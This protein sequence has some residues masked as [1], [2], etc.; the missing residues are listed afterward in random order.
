M[1]FIEQIFLSNTGGTIANVTAQNALKVDG[2]AVNQPVTKSGSW[3]NLGI[4]G[5]TITANAGTNLNTSAL[6]LESGG[7]LAS[8]K[9]KTDNLDVLLSTRL[10]PADTLAAI[11]TV[12]TITNPVAVTKSGTWSNLGISGGTINT[13]SNV[14]HIDDNSGSLTVDNGGTFAVQATKSGTWS[15]LGISGGTIAAT[16]SGTWNINTLTSI[17]NPI[18]VTKSGTWSNLGISGGTIASTQSGNW[19]VRNQD[20]AGNALTTNSTTPSAK[21]ALDQNIVSILG[22]APTT[23]GKL[24]IKGADGDVFVRQ[25]TAANL[26]AT[27]VGTGTFA[28]QAAKSGT[29]SNL[30]IS[31]GT[32]NTISNVIHIDDNAG[33]LT[34]DNGGT[35][36]VQASKSG[37][38]SNLGISGGTITVTQ[39]TGTNLHTVVDSGTISTITNVVHVDDNAGSLTVDNG[40]TF[41]VQATK[42]GTWSNLGIS[43]GTIAATQSGTWNVGTVSTLTTITNPVAVTKSGAWTNLGISGGTINTITNVVHIDDNS[44]SLTVD[45]GGTFAVQAAKSGAWTNLGISGGTIAVTQATASNLNATVVGTGT[46]AVQESG[47]QLIVDNAGFTDGTSKLIMAGYIF[48]EVAGT[49][50][51]ENDAAAARINANRAKVGV[52][53]DGTTR[54]RYATVTAA[55][56]LK[57]DASGVAVP[58]TDNSGS[59]TVDA[60]VGTPL[61]ATV[62]PS[63]T[64]GWTMFS[65]PNNNSNTPLTT[66]VVTVKGSAGTLGGYFIYNPNSTV[67]FVQVFDVSGTVTLG[68]TRPNVMF[69]IPPLSSANMEIGNGLNFANA[70]KIAATTTSSGSVAPTTGLEV[71]MWY[72]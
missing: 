61:F 15:N 65:T 31:G 27:I 48:D 11:T 54:A 21:F 5:G 17:T 40:G 58:I 26:N 66:T 59:L 49:A 55:N 72:K 7:N 64:G 35:F 8:I 4:S 46:F 25:T 24:D 3:I 53:E 43:G 67:S 1:G 12:G 9:S 14:V 45:N 50:L 19:S 42:S 71:S 39:A 18:A 33:S 47:A 20:G 44:G 37:T 70:I 69:G 51:T 57:V 68:T 22:T 56:A 10:K 41:A 6:A 2:S 63:T 60:P 13:I 32:I 29:W 62:T 28:V 52:I 30:G 34:V 23:V 36:V 38:W 16:Q